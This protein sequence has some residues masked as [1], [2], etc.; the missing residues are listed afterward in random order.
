MKA[1]ESIVKSKRTLGIV[2]AVLAAVSVLFSQGF[3]FSYLE[4]IDTEAVE[5]TDEHGE[6]I[7]VVKMTQDA[8]MTM[9]QISIHQVLDYLGDISITE[10]I[11][12]IAVPKSLRLDGYFTTLFNIIISPNAP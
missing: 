2:L 4:S 3:Y 10:A 5:H 9:A 6:D 12:K 1:Q 8:V 11:I 7:P